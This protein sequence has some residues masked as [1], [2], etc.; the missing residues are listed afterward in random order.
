MVIGHSDS[1]IKCVCV[2]VLFSFFFEIEPTIECNN[3]FNNFN[4]Q[5]F[6]YCTNEKSL[7]SRPTNGNYK[8]LF[9]FRVESNQN[10]CVYEC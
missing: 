9:E 4:T 5:H 6:F 8:N 1:A 7:E 10:L 2:F 3:I